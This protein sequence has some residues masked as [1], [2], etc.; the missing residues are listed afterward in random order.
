MKNED[1][2]INTSIK[3][4]SRSVFAQADESF[5]NDGGTDVGFPKMEN[6]QK[7]IM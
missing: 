3:I 4:I 6:I 2:S 1:R 7:Q 5:I